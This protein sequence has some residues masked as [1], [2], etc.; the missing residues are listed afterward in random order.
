MGIFHYRNRFTVNPFAI[1]IPP[2]FAVPRK[3]F[4]KTYSS[5]ATLAQYHGPRE[6]VRGSAMG[7]EPQI[8]QSEMRIKILTNQNETTFSEGARV[9]ALFQL[10]LL[11]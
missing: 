5:A 6:Y 2:V 8:N 4:F 3:M 11:G 9:S 1:Y 7:I 10:C